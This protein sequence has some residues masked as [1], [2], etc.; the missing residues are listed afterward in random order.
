MF[1]QPGSVVSFLSLAAP[2][3][4]GTGVGALCGQLAALCPGA[5]GPDLPLAHR[6]GKHG[7]GEGGNRGWVPAK[8]PG[9]CRHSLGTPSQGVKN[10]LH[11]GA[12]STPK[13]G[14][15]LV[16]RGLCRHPR[17]PALGLQCRREPPCSTSCRV[18]TGIGQIPWLSVPGKFQSVFGASLQRWSLGR[19]EGDGGGS[20]ALTQGP[21][22]TIRTGTF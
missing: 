13:A 22:F 19:D 4:P 5:V 14:S 20:G 8:P 7:R 2:G 18:N 6:L 21:R 12:E 17:P 9:S 11:R 10:R 1:T 16:P 3:G 15:P